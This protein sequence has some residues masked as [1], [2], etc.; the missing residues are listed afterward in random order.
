MLLD[1]VRVVGKSE[2]KDVVLLGITHLCEWDTVQQI[3]ELLRQDAHNIGAELS[4]H[5]TS[6]VEDI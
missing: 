6:T 1:S 5:I 4:F 3:C 2:G